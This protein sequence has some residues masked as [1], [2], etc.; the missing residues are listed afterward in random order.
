MCVCVCVRADD[1]RKKF[2]KCT[3]RERTYQRRRP[4]RESDKERLRDV[5]EQAKKKKK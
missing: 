1:G 3:E 4:S 5:R 2:F